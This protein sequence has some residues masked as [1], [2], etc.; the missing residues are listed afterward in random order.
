MSILGENVRWRRKLLGLSQAELAA[1]IHVNHRQPTGSYISRLEHGILDP[2]LSTVRSLAKA[3][4]L[5]PWQLIADI[6][7]NTDFWR[8]YLDLSPTQKR[9]IQHN[10]KWLAE[11]R[12]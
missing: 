6:T 10:I 4:R 3:L 12:K 7:D 2:R 5:K 9:E 11:G 8:A 1:Q